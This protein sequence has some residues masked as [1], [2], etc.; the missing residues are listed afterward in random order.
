MWTSNFLISF[1]FCYRA[2][3]QLLFG[4]AAVVLLLG[5]SQDNWG[6]LFAPI[7]LIFTP[8]LWEN[9]HFML[10]NSSEQQRPHCLQLRFFFIAIWSCYASMSGKLFPPFVLL[11]LFFFLPPP[12]PL[13]LPKD[14]TVQA[15][16]LT[17]EGFFQNIKGWLWFFPIQVRF[18]KLDSA[19]GCRL[20]FPADSRL[21]FSSFQKII[22]CLLSSSRPI[23]LLSCLCIG[24]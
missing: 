3:L 13:P 6:L 21:Q 12:L 14:T 11:F 5:I 1:S 18:R 10:P 15:D 2:H 9:F 20:S 8:I 7:S 23:L 22:F 17:T 16:Y 4:L 19:A 24:L